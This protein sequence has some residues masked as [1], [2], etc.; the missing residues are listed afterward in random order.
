[1]STIDLREIRRDAERGD[2][3]SSDTV[4][5]L[6]EHVAQLEDEIEGLTEYLRTLEDERENP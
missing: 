4:R 2:M 6:I 3:I 5:E 1:M